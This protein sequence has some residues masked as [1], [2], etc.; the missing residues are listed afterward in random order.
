MT[1]SSLS[2]GEG[3]FPENA[4]EAGKLRPFEK[5]E[6][7][8]PSR[9]ERV[10]LVVEDNIIN[11]QV[12]LGHLRQLGYSADVAANGLEALKAIE[13]Q[14]YDIILMDCQMPELD[15]YEA[16]RE[17][18]R[19]ETGGRRSWIIALTANVMIGDREKC[20]AA[21]MD[22]YVGKPFHRAELHAAIERG[23]AKP[24]SPLN[25]KIVQSLVEDDAGFLAVLTGLFEKSGPESV[26]EMEQALQASDAEKLATAAHTLKGS[27]GNLGATTL[28]E[29]CARLEEAG[30][31]GN[32]AEAARL[33]ASVGKELNHFIAAL[34]AYHPPKG[35]S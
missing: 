8:P 3:G 10:L 35:P 33:F 29:L 20:L 31:A 4:G 30:L 17:I 28:R 12:A 6:T 2:Q 5:A 14:S 15:G 11:Q 26:V 1:A 7:P 32:M 23:A 13:I 9:R 27:C 19:R 22:D 16:T 18:R 24:E 21:G 34:K 25:D